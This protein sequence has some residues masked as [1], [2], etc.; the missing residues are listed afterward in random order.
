MPILTRNVMGKLALLLLCAGFC[1]AALAAS[2]LTV[3]QMEQKL[4]TLHNEQDVK[5][6]KK[7]YDVELTERVS[8]ARLARWETDFPGKATREMLVALSDASAFL[9]LPPADIP[10]KE[11]PDAATRNQILTRTVHYVMTTVHQLPVFSARRSTTH[12]EDAP[13]KDEG[14][15]LHLSPNGSAGNGMTADTVAFESIQSGARQL[16]VLDRSSLVSTYRDGQ[17]VLDAHAGK[18]W[19]SGGQNF[20]LT[21]SGEFGP[22]LS[23]V[24]GDAIRG[25]VRWGHWEQGAAGPV[26][27]LRYTVPQNISHY[28]LSVGVVGKSGTPQSPPYHGEIAVD[29]ATGSVLRLTIESELKPPHQIFDSSIVVEYEPVP[30]G[31]MTYICPVKGVALSKIS[32]PAAD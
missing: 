18:G 9:D 22:I 5:V 12:F 10:A 32:Y 11:I 7:L 15:I 27:V 3:D 6:A 29:P 2:R 24:V 31:K 19:K 4:T 8:S 26:A 1:P 20:G 28:G 13:T 25:E 14:H 30:I 23:T 16:R 17:P 21:T